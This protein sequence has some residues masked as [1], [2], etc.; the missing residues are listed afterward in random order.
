MFA[1]KDI[2]GVYGICRFQERLV[3]SQ[4]LKRCLKDI[5]FKPEELQY[6]QCHHLSSPSAPGLTLSPLNDFSNVE[7]LALDFL[8]KM[9]IEVPFEK[10]RGRKKKPVFFWILA[11]MK[12]GEKRQAAVKGEMERYHKR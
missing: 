12:G 4:V 2:F 6:L 1:S 3:I 11:V 8:A 10:R 9:F 7:P 5:H